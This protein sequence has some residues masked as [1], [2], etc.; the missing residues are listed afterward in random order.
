MIIVGPE[1]AE[2]NSRVVLVIEWDA[3]DED[4]I[5]SEVG[6]KTVWKRTGTRVVRHRR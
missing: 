4:L 6:F 3:R 1:W 5:W 2:H